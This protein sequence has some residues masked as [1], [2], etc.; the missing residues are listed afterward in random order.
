MNYVKTFILALPLSLISANSYSSV[1]VINDI[2]PKI[3]VSHPYYGNNTYG[4]PKIDL[5]KTIEGSEI[6]IY[7]ARYGGD[8]EHTENIIKIFSLKGPSPQKVLER[9]LSD[10]EFVLKSGVLQSIIGNYIETLCDVCDGWEVS[11]PKDIFKIPLKIEASNFKVTVLMDDL[12]KKNLLAAL[13]AQ[14]EANI[15][16]QLAYG[17]RSYSEYANAVMERISELLR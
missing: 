5:F 16:E 8:G 6:L 15:N 7:Q 14:V 9:N 3:D 12:E 4:P 1:N 11:S 10:V 17:N 13:K 2:L